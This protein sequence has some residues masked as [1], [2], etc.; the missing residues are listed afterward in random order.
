MKRLRLLAVRKL[1]CLMGFLFF[2][3]IDSR[4]LS[5]PAPFIEVQ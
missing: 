3:R 4:E 2:L 1:R 5:T